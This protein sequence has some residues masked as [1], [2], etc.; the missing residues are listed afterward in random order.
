MRQGGGRDQEI[1]GTDGAADT[2]QVSA[3]GAGDVG[4][5]IVEADARERTAE[6]LDRSEISG[7]AS[8]D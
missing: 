8:P 6:R 2:L 1:V 7:V 3:N 5:A 4:S